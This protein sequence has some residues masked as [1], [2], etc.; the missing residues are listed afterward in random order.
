MSDVLLTGVHVAAA[1]AVVLVIGCAGRSAARLLRQ[2]ETVGEIVAGLLA[3]PAAVALLGRSKFDAVLPGDVLDIMKLVA[4][5]GLV[6]FL[7]GL[8]HKLR[9]G[10]HRS[11]LRTSVWLVAGGLVPA[12]LAGVL[13]AGWI[14]LADEPGVRG[15]APLPAFLLMCAVALSITAVPV[16]AR[17]LAERN[18]TETLEGRLSMTAAVVIDTA[19]WLL[20]SVAVG[21]STGE[22][23]GFVQSVVVLGG[24]AAAALGVR[25]ALRTRAAHNLCEQRPL[26][27][28]VLLGAIALTMALTVERLGLTAIFGAVL[29]GLALPPDGPWQQVANRVTSLGR[30][31]IPFFF[32][33]TGVT[34]FAGGIG[35][36]PWAL[37]AG[38]ILLAALGKGVGSYFGARM[39][40]Q[41][42]Q[43][44]VTVGVLMNTRGLTELIV[45]KVGYNADIL[46][47]P[48]FVALIV[49]AVATTVMT[50]P[51]LLL[52]KWSGDRPVRA[53]V[54]SKSQDDSP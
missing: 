7:V 15:S 27:T 53:S 18:A 33:V 11:S 35:P 46:T 16:L 1:L 52:T 44:A 2:P 3:G 43:T 34:V 40:G 28:A 24:G 13:F 39:A 5:V 29:V 41:P 17:I 47:R 12:M 49:M 54:G 10:A 14:L 48:V 38:A 21:L 6:L 30:G 32:V 45:L 37:T 31:M 4:E 8:A 26:I 9:L 19:G 25:G 22:L 51:L 36:L 20:L 42:K 50:G 23:N